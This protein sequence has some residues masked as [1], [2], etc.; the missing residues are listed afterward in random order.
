M[1][2]PVA[3]V[4]L[5]YHLHIASSNVLT[6]VGRLYLPD[7]VGIDGVENVAIDIINSQIFSANGDLV[8]VDV[9]SFDA[10]SENINN[11]YIPM[12]FEESIDIQAAITNFDGT[13]IG[14]ITSVT[15]SKT[16]KFVYTT[17]SPTQVA[18]TFGYLISINTTTLQIDN[19]LKLTDCYLPDHVTTTSD[20]KTIIIS[21]E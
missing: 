17:A 21:C 2:S 10:S 12:T 8:T 1:S 15:Y 3:I 13:S 6:Q 18:E 20:G 14:A 16:N 19:I 9:S 11:E 5:L 7:N 4:A